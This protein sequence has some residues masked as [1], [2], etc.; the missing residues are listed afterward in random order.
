MISKSGL[1]ALKALA[2]LAELP[3][4]SYAGA[5]A[6]AKKI[7]A[8]QNYL[9]KLLQALSREGLLVSQ[10]GLRGGFRLA[11]DPR[12]MT[13]FDVIEPLESV[14]RWSGC[15]L[16]RNSCSSKAPCA[17]HLRWKTTRDSYLDFLKQ[18]TIADLL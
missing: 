11:Q 15:F 1:H 16:G 2:V 3:Q 17:V 12:K 7:S 8:P 13:L 6:I 10:K 18:T 9:G 5:T 14:S 4:G